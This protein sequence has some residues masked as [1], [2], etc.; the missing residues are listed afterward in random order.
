MITLVK[1]GI[2]QQQDQLS[3]PASLVGTVRRFGALGPAYQVMGIVSN[4]RL[5]DTVLRIHVLESE[6]D[7]DYPAPLAFLDPEA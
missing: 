2:V 3:S 5:E 7:A 6:E 4:G 1:G